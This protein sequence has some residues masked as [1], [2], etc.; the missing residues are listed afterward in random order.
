ME[1]TQVIKEMLGISQNHESIDTKVHKV[2]EETPFHEILSQNL[3]KLQGENIIE[4]AVGAIQSNS[5][6][7]A[8]TRDNQLFLLKDRNKEKEES[9][10]KTHSSTIISM[11]LSISN[12]LASLSSTFELFIGVVSDGEYSFL[13]SFE[14][15]EY[16]PKRIIWD[17][18]DDNMLY[19]IS[20]RNIYTFETLSGEIKVLYSTEEE[21]AGFHIN[22][23]G[24]NYTALLSSKKAILVSFDGYTEIPYE[25][26]DEICYIKTESLAIYCLQ[27]NKLHIWN[28]SQ[29]RELCSAHCT[30]SDPILKHCEDSDQ[31]FAF[32][33]KRQKLIIFTFDEEDN[34]VSSLQIRLQNSFQDINIVFHYNTIAGQPPAKGNSRIEIITLGDD[35]VTSYII[36]SEQSKKIGEKYILFSDNIEENKEDQNFHTPVKY[37]KSEEIKWARKQMLENQYE[38]KFI[39]KANKNDE[40]KAKIDN[41]KKLEICQVIS[42]DILPSKPIENFCWEVKSSGVMTEI[43]SQQLSESLEK[44]YQSMLKNMHELVSESRIKSIISSA[45]DASIPKLI[46]NYIM[47]VVTKVMEE[48]TPLATEL[49]KQ[50]MAAI[51]QYAE[52]SFI[53]IIEEQRT[54]E[55]KLQ[56]IEKHLYEEYKKREKNFKEKKIIKNIPKYEEEFEKKNYERGIIELLATKDLQL[57]SSKLATLNPEVVFSTPLAYDT[58]F[59]LCFVL[60]DLMKAGKF[61]CSNLMEKLCQIIPLNGTQRRKQL[62]RVF[63]DRNNHLE[64]FEEII[65]NRML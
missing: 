43:N 27:E 6:L 49:I 63:L 56:S 52:N 46:E 2:D 33:Q 62:F 42:F 14:G 28:I 65:H 7:T 11:S 45:V 26:I 44:N 41:K 64:R 23:S 17:P 39:E 29:Q 61:E 58:Y 9:P 1:R 57:I 55:M 48:I 37:V 22:P 35:K 5:Q 20:E 59:D 53:E 4:N 19:L 16:Q 8:F 13:Q 40:S 51:R 21:I 47:R 3:H 60:I 24:R 25:N 54:H 15:L 36:W 18:L 32:S 34:I 38:V 10:C 30:L 50:E 31:I 12:K